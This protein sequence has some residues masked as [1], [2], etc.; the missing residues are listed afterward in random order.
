MR[1]VI[2]LW[3]ELVK[4]F[5]QRGTWAGPAVLAL[6]VSLMIWGLWRYG[7]ERR[8]E[9][10][11]GEQMLVGG[12]LLSG[13][14]PAR[15][16][17][18]PALLVLVP[19]LVAAVAGGLVAGETKSGVLRTWL[20]RPVSRWTVLTAK[21]LAAWIHALFLTGFLG[22]FTLGL[23]YLVFGG[24][25]LVDLRSGGGI[26]IFDEATGLQRLALAYGL[27]GLAMCAMASL[28][29]LASVLFD[30]PL[31]AAAVAVAFLP[32]S[33]ALAA[34]PYFEP[35][36]PYLLTTHLDWWR[37]AFRANL[38][39]ADF[40]QPLSCILGYCAVPYILASVIF[41]RKDITG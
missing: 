8:W 11:M 26:I 40:R 3:L 19:L 4:I 22:L 24:G 15:H 37:E 13:L 31:V 29:L 1:L 39:W 38:Q 23:G 41:W 7:P 20:C 28:A 36:Q 27:A 17:L 30:N 34:L 5:R 35:L 6:I 18:E 33:T 10:R 2:S 32:I 25:D 14:T 12:K 16:V 9:R 21:Q